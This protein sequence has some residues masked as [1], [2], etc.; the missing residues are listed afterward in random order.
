MANPH[1]GNIGDI[2]KHVPLATILALERPAA[3]CESHS[4]S[5]KYVLSTSVERDYGI[6]F[7]LKNVSRSQALQSSAFNRTLEELEE[8][9]GT[10]PS[11]PGS[12]LLALL[13]LRNCAESF[14]FCDTDRASM[15]SIKECA[16]WI[17][18]NDRRVQCVAGDGV[19]HLSNDLLQKSES[20]LL[21]ML[22]FIDPFDPFDGLDLGASPMDLFCLAANAGARGVLWYG[23]HS[24][25]DRTG[26]WDNML[27]TLRSYKID[28]S[29]AVLW[30]GEIC[31][32]V[33][34]DPD[35][36][37]DPG[38][39]GCGILTAGLSDKTTSRCAELGKE[40]SRIY[41]RSR[42]TSGHS[43]AFDFSTVSIW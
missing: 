4:G 11:Y 41:Q 20:E 29:S 22:V 2:W 43:G 9:N 12:P 6:F 15:A 21:N 28:S 35:F 31:M 30:C 33:L 8:M 32:K 38:V 40:L 39:K 3:Y 23:F 26:C 17:G 10:V 34:D 13:L 7:F 24:G 1:F 14:V 18:V 36:N 27:R 19:A 16:P 5:A 37:I 42:F 25:A